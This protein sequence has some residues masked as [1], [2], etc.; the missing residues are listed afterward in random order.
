MWLFQPANWQLKSG[1][2]TKAMQ[3]GSPV[4]SCS[5]LTSFQFVNARAL[6]TA[7]AAENRNKNNRAKWPG[8]K[9]PRPN[10]V[11]KSSWSRLQANWGTRACAFVQIWWQAD[12]RKT[13]NIFSWRTWSGPDQQYSC[14]T[15]TCFYWLHIRVFSGHRYSQLCCGWRG[16]QFIYHLKLDW[17]YIKR[18]VHLH[19]LHALT[20][21]LFNA[22]L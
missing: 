13:G 5:G 9:R 16:W 14:W 15:W 4:A 6:N 19:E 1:E 7:T 21:Y 12:N 3:R 8:A 11:F 18:F 20:K 17:F 2:S 10:P 22:R